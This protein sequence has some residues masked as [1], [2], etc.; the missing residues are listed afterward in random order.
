MRQEERY[1]ELRY[2]GHVDGESEVTRLSVLPDENGIVM[3]VPCLVK[4]GKRDGLRKNTSSKGSP[5]GL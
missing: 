2:R 3:D 1:S 5:S 4:L